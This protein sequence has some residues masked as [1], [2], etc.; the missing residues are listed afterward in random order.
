MFHSRELIPRKLS[1]RKRKKLKSYLHQHIHNSS[2]W[3]SQRLEE[4]Q[5]LTLWWQWPELADTHFCPLAGVTLGKSSQS[6]GT[7]VS[8]IHPGGAQGVAALEG[9]SR[10]PP[11]PHVMEPSRSGGGCSGHD[12]RAPVVRESPGQTHLGWDKDLQGTEGLTIWG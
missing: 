4:T 7:S 1:K 10:E 3:E 2:A 6:L 8:S 9:P 11:R 5:H 12:G